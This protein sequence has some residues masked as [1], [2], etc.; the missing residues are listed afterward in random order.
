MSNQPFSNKPR[1]SIL[2]I[3]SL[4]ALLFLP[5]TIYTA[6]PIESD[7]NIQA[8]RDS[9]KFHRDR[10]VEYIQNGNTKE[11][12]DEFDKAIKASHNEGYI[13]GKEE[14]SKNQSARIYAKYVVLSIVAGLYF[15]AIFVAILWWSDIS[16]Q[17]KSIRRRFR[18]REIVKGIKVK[19][20]PELS[21]R[22]IAIARS[23]EKLR[24]AIK[25]EDDAE[26]NGLAS[27]I[28]PRLDELAKQAMLLLERQQILTDYMKD[29]DIKKLEDEVR[30]CEQKL[31][32]EDDQEAKDALIYQMT[33]TKNKQENYHRA[34]ARIRT[35]EA[36]LK[37]IAARI[38]ATSLDL[39]SLPSVLIKKQEFL[40]RI[41]V[42]LDEEIGITKRATESLMEE[43][44]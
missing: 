40:E 11:S 26:L 22:A 29:M 34:R 42:E 9:A 2:I 30:E 33:Q 4:I 18:I 41:S 5:P 13:K 27:N 6:Y 38:D 28:L 36:I 32:K 7:P 43:T 24:D 16:S 20:I 39:M 35:S 37:G 25:Q 10:G 31:K 19:L 3:I 12:I 8:D 23:K 1:K 44:I 14:G 21:E 17:T 15:A